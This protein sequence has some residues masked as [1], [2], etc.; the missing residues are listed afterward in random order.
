MADSPEIAIIDVNMLSCLGLKGLILSLM[1]KAV[2]RCFTT[3]EAFSDDTPD[4]YFHYFVCPQIAFEHIGFFLERQ[5]KT[6]LVSPGIVQRT[7]L[8]R[9]RLF[10]CSKSKAELMQAFMFLLQQGHG[11]GRRLPAEYWNKVQK[12]PDIH[13]T[14][15]EID[16]LVL[17]VKGLLNKEIAEKLHVGLTTVVTHRK[18]IIEKLGIRSASGLAVYAVMNGYV[19]PD[20]F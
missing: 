9:F 13:L 1:P 7:Q 5:H 3:F 15:R 4:M 12:A 2:V 16:V 8:D 20:S 10:D 18:H 11:K 14:P 17:I 6:I 19:D